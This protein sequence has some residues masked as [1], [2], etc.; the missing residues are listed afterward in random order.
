VYVCALLSLYVQREGLYGCSGLLPVASLLAQT[1]G[2]ASPA[3][4]PLYVFRWWMVLT[5]TQADVDTALQLFVLLGVVL[6][7]AS[8]CFPHFLLYG[9]LYAVYTSCSVLGQ[10]FFSFQWD[11]LLCEAGVLAVL[12]AF[13]HGGGA[14]KPAAT[15]RGGSISV[16]LWLVR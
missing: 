15:S 3:L 6:A 13:E 11:F 1:E 7:L 9:A 2:R 10:R 16:S 4:W 14:R 8:L 12:V 5:Q